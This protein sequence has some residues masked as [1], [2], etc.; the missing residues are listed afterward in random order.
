VAAAPDLVV[1]DSAVA[2][3]ELALV[4]A[5]LAAELR[6]GLRAVEDSWVRLRVSVEEAPAAIEEVPPPQPVVADEPLW[7]ESR[8][9]EHLPELDYIVQ[10]VEEAPAAIEEESPQPVRADELALAESRETEDL[11][12]LDFIVEV[13]EEAPVAVEEE[14]PQPVVAGELPLVELRE[15][16][17]PPD[18]DY[19]VEVVE[20]PPA[21]TQQ[22]RSNYPVLPEPEEGAIEETDAALRRIREHM[23]EEPP[24][25]KR[26]LRR[27]F[28]LASGVSALCAV[29]V[30][31]LDVQLQVAQ[32][33]GWL[34]F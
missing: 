33:P 8:E 4:D 15:A 13:V 16:E 26:K 19:V 17:H 11:P 3:P 12:V 23:T 22:T 21:L 5:D 27:R 6:R 10:V 34:G 32:L 7:T 30:L 25:S 2:S 14:P 29:G 28:V 18:L 31:A 20:Q 24:A 1:G 9:S